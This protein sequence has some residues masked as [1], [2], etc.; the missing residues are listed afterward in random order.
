M[1]YP[2]RFI[3]LDTLNSARVEEPTVG[4]FG[5]GSPK[6]FRIKCTC[7]AAVDKYLIIIISSSQE[8]GYMGKLIVELPGDVHRELKK[9]AAANN[10]TLKDIITE[11]IHEYLSATEKGPA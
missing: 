5:C 9:K 10:M 2:G 11:L 3:L 6:Y 7:K 1:L 4:A 8:V